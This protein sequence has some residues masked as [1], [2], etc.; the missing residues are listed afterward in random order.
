MGDDVVGEIGFANVSTA[1]GWAKVGG[2]RLGLFF[3][4]VVLLFFLSFFLC[5]CFILCV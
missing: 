4:C 5:V 2:A 3:S 1:A